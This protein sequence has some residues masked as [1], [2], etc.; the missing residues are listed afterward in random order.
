MTTSLESLQSS[1]VEKL[2]EH[3]FLAEVLQEAWLRHGLPVS[4]LR[5]KV[6]SFG[7]D[8][9]LECDGRTRHIQ[10][11]SSKWDATTSR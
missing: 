7:Y 11:K 6:D 10:L 1:Y 5:S 4:V 3:V 2:R 8:L 9:V